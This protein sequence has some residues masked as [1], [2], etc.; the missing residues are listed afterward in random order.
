MDTAVTQLSNV[1][2]NRSEHDRRIA[3]KL[4][5]ELGP[6]VCDLLAD[7]LV[8][9]VMLNPDGTLWVERQGAEMEEA[10]R[11]SASQAESLMGTLAAIKRTEITAENPT[12]QAALPVDGSRFQGVLSPT[13]VGGPAFNLR[14]RATRIITLDEYYESGIITLHQMEAIKGA[15]EDRQNI[16]VVGGTGTGKTTLTNAII[17]YIAIA[18]PNHRLLILEDTLELQC[19]AKNV[20]FLHATEHAD[21]RA[22]VKTT[23][24]MRPDRIIVGEVRDGAALSMLDAWNTG[25][26]GGVA[27]L[28][29]NSAALAFVRLEG[30]VGQASLTPQNNLI[31]AAVDVI[32]FIE[33]DATHPAKRVVREVIRVSG[34][35][36]GQYITSNL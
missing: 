5:R 27:T 22:L 30:L 35:S 16:L 25:H 20:V 8:V 9:E 36:D 31:G 32:V 33:K 2:A 14:K 10:G 26:P 23:L 11:M 4:R 17:D 21:M 1:L 18:T 34:F 29:A 6:L 28:H 7:P 3:E 24:R 12:L 19:A 15:V 13:A